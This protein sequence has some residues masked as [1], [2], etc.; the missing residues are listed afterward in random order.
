MYQVIEGARQL[1][2]IMGTLDCITMPKNLQP[3]A[4]SI[5][6]LN[7]YINSSRSSCKWGSK[8]RRCKFVDIN[9]VVGVLPNNI[10]IYRRVNWRYMPEKEIGVLME[11]KS[12]QRFGEVV[13]HVD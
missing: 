2:R 8:R 4:V 5:I 7:R 12:L 3:R 9:C 11:E 10:G 1:K 6:I 13:G